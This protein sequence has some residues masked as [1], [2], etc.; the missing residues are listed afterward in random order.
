MPGQ[1][2]TRQSVRGHRVGVDNPERQDRT[3]SGR[4]ANADGA[5]DLTLYLEQLVVGRC[6]SAP[7]VRK[8]ASQRVYRRPYLAI[9]KVIGKICGCDNLCRKARPIE[10]RGDGHSSL[11]HLAGRTTLGPFGVGGP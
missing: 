10:A 6:D 11:W 3:R 1:A 8:A 9:V 7:Y 2:A 5:F 4:L